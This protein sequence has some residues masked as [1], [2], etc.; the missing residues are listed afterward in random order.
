VHGCRIAHRDQCRTI[1]TQSVI[2]VEQADLSSRAE[3]LHV[4]DCD[5]IELVQSFVELGV[6]RAR[7]ICRTRA[8]SLKS[9]N[10]STQQV[11]APAAAGAPQINRT[12]IIAG[13]RQIT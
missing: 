9:G 2:E 8:R 5:Q 6:A 12:L 3:P 7:D 13:A 4:I 11:R 10:R 1:R